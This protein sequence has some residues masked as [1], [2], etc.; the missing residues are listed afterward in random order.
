MSDA[1]DILRLIESMS[2]RLA[3]VEVAVR[4]IPHLQSQRDEHRAMLQVQ[5][6]RNRAIL[7]AV[8]KQLADFHDRSVEEIIDRLTGVVMRS[9]VQTIAHWA[10]PSVLAGVVFIV[11][12][13]FHLF[14]VTR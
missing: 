7:E 9:T 13:L 12:W 1:A 11:G 14:F 4:E 2:A 5:E 10:L 8:Q 3:A 6:E